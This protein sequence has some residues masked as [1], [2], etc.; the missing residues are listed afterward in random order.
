M[1]AFTEITDALVNKGIAVVRTDTIYGI[2]ALASKQRA[3]E[4]VYAAKHRDPSKQ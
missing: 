3:V 1:D 2:I 4:K